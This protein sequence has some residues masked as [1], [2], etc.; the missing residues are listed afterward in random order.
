MAQQNLY[1]EKQVKILLNRILCDKEEVAEYI[2]KIQPIELPS[3]KE[4]EEGFNTHDEKYYIFLEGAKWMRD[5]I[6]N[7]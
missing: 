4:I 7:K 3:D 6:L 1:T 2:E 5:K